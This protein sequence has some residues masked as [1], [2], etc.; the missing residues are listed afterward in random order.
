M[1]VQST[2]SGMGRVA[3]M[4]KAALSRGSTL[5]DK[6]IVPTRMDRAERASREQ[7]QAARFAMPPLEPLRDDLAPVATAMEQVIAGRAHETRLALAGWLAGGHVLIDGAPGLGKTTLARALAAILG[8][9]MTRV[10]FTADLMA[11]DLLGGAI[12]DKGSE[13]FILH[14]GPIFT[15]ILLADEINRAAPRAQSALLEAM[16]EGRVSMDGDSLDLAADFFVIATQNPFGQI[17]TF[18]LPESQLDR[19]LLRIEFGP[20]GREVERDILRTGDRS[21]E[22]ASLPNLGDLLARDGVAIGAVHVGD[23][24]TDYVQDLIELSRDPARQMGG[25]SVR[26]GLGLMTAARAWSWLHGRDAVE[27]EDIQAVFPALAEHRLAGCEGGVKG[28]AR[29]SAILNG[30]AV[31]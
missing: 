29:S 16:A 13:R 15:E 14:K 27:P 26:A 31:P 8:R 17:G 12:W 22:I 4:A 5:L 11:S 20:L 10:Q 25:L 9:R 21:G 1:T 23:R 28:H 30:V 2:R 7:P 6:Q 19:F 24:V 3:R 18:P